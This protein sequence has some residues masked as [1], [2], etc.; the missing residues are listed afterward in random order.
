MDAAGVTSPG[1]GIS[2]RTFGTTFRGFDRGEVRTFLSELAEQQQA[3]VERAEQAESVV[4]DLRTRLE[5][6]EQ[7]LKSADEK[8]AT[9]E[10]HLAELESDRGE[11]ESNPP[12]DP[13]LAVKAF[14]EKVTE[15]LQI[16]VSA[17]NSIRSEAE[18]WASQRRNE[19]E[20]QAANAIASAQREVAEIVAR[21]ETNVD[22]LKAAEQA[23]RNWLQAA[24][25]AIGQV[26]ER[27]AVG[28]GE[29]AAVI[30][31]IRELGPPSAPE[32]PM[33]FQSSDEPNQASFS[34]DRPQVLI[35]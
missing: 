9:A 27:P 7:L 13:E 32:Q 21:E 8:Y 34:S 29:L 25:S 30:G 22:Q 15:V 5:S 35:D 10:A 19:A 6:V 16:A 4:E 33:D 12:S 23:L 2:H 18:A 24:H 3:L 1:S 31:R 26:L 20:E 11:T 28:P 14:G 17:G